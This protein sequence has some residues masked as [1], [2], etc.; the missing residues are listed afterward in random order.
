MRAAA[1]GAVRHSKPSASCFKS[2]TTPRSLRFTVD[3]FTL[4]SLAF[5]NDSACRCWRRATLHVVPERRR[6]RRIGHGHQQLTSE[7]RL[8]STIHSIGPDYNTDVPLSSTTRP[9]DPSVWVHARRR[10]HPDRP[11]QRSTGSSS[12]ITSNRWESPARPTRVT[13][14]CS[15]RRLGFV[16]RRTRYDHD[17]GQPLAAAASDWATTA[18]H[19]SMIFPGASDRR[20][21]GG[22]PSGDQP[23]AWLLRR[24]VQRGDHHRHALCATIRY[25]TDGKHADREHGH[26]VRRA[27]PRQRHDDTADECLQSRPPACSL[28][29][30]RSSLPGERP[31]AE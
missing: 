18:K 31:S 21:S 19:L 12:G 30:G 14:I 2:D 10:P 22:L 17:F 15:V 7:V 23:P 20:L 27:D 1:F 29:N 25:I 28:G 8:M 6:H 3:R 11:A 5:E 4:P 9:T 24:A 13:V 26:R 16:R